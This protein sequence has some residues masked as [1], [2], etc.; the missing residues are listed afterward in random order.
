MNF[1]R[2]KYSLKFIILLII[3][4]LIFQPGLVPASIHADSAGDSL[5]DIGMQKEET[6]KK[7]EDAR[8]EEENYIKQVNEVEDNMLAVLDDLEELNKKL[9]E[10]KNNISD[11][12]IDI[13]M[14][15]EELKKI[16]AE[17]LEKTE[18]LNKRVTEIYKK[19]NSSSIDVI[20]KSVGFIDFFTR[21]KMVSAIAQKDI[22]IIN[23]IKDKK[24]E[25]IESQKNIIK[26]HEEELKQKKEL[27]SL[28]EESQK[29]KNELEKIYNQKKE[30]LTIATANKEALLTLERQLEQKQ[31][32]I[33]KVLQQYNYGSSPTGKLMWPVY[34]KL[35][36]GFG[37]RR[38]Y[39][40]SVRFH[41]GID[42]W[43]PSGSNIFAA[44]SGQ[45]LKAEYHGGYG[46]CILIY[47]GGDFATFYAHLSGFAVS[48][49]QTVQKGQIIGYV[50]TTGYTTG[51]HLHF[52]VRV[53]GNVQNPLNYF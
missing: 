31:V 29:K 20:F 22:E 5:K 39:S 33:T 17:I 3:S 23:E 10:S 51:P 16:E 34:G 19:G 52:E 8:N 15:K 37:N 24:Q 4:I 1:F 46:Y 30:L 9:D 26:M 41:A 40:G 21:L 53:K 50:G 35:S 32:E 13:A 11:M 7:V 49:G 6:K 36:S 2:N 44:E 42:I 14:Q 25:L 48:V 38:S 12:T 27:E 45:V 47:H 43:A 18:I 28:I